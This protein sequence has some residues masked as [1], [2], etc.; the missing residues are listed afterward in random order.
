[1][2]NKIVSS[3][4]HHNNQTLNPSE[5]ITLTDEEWKEFQNIVNDIF[6][7]F[8]EQ[9]E[10][11]RYLLTSQDVSFCCLVRL[12]FNYSE[13][14]G[15]FGCTPQAITKRKR[16]LFNQFDVES[17]TAFERKLKNT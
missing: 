10:G 7:G 16:R 5:K 17:T 13:I 14:A 15:I 3:I 6:P 2:Y 8:I 4:D 11:P 1:M 9:L 12:E